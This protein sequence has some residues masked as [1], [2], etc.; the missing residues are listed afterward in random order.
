MRRRGR[1]ATS[2]G[3]RLASRH[4][5]PAVTPLR[6]QDHGSHKVHAG[7]EERRAERQCG[8]LLCAQRAGKK[9]EQLRFSFVGSGLVAAQVPLNAPHVA[10]ATF[11][12]WRWPSP[13]SGRRAESS[14]SRC[15]R[16]GARSIGVLFQ[17]NHGH[18]QSGATGSRV[19]AEGH[20]AGREAPRRWVARRAVQ[21][22]RVGR[23]YDQHSHQ[24][25]AQAAHGVHRQRPFVRRAAPRQGRE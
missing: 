20:V 6:V 1:C 18:I 9:D 21:L 16:Y 24:A 5:R 25:R 23:L 10:H 8:S 15:S 4:P 7:S 19:H 22:D 12:H 17:R 11:R 2:E 14:R 13:R 3:F